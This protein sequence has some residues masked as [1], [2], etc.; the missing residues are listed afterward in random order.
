FILLQVDG[1]PAPPCGRASPV[2]V[3]EDERTGGLAVPLRA[4]LE[5]IVVVAARA[6]GDGEYLRDQV[7]IDGGK[8]R[9]LLVPALCVLA[10]CVVHVL[11]QPGIAR[12]S[13]GKRSNGGQT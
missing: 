7:E 4:V 13:A 2:G 10:E 3:I 6:T 12:P 9:I 11:A 5:F 1:E 8:K